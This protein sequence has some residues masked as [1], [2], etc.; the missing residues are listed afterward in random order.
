MF[1]LNITIYDPIRY[2]LIVDYSFYHF[3]RLL[4]MIQNFNFQKLRIIK[5]YINILTKLTT[6]FRVRTF[7]G[8]SR[9]IRIEFF[10]VF[11]LIKILHEFFLT[12]IG[13][14]YPNQIL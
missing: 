10:Q 4:K 7:F 6:V 12:F 5:L 14:T 2:K 9:F 1:I 13:L 3:K 8:L 11:F